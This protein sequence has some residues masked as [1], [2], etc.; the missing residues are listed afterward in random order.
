MKV[1]GAPLFP[2][3]IIPLS[4][5]SCVGHLNQMGTGGRYIPSWKRLTLK[6]SSSH[7]RFRCISSSPCISLSKSMNSTAPALYLDISRTADYMNSIL[8]TTQWTRPVQRLP[9]SGG[10]GVHAVD[11]A[12]AHSGRAHRRPST[13]SAVSGASSTSKTAAG[14]AQEAPPPPPPSRSRS[15]YSSE[16]DAGKDRS[17]GSGDKDPPVYRPRPSRTSTNGARA[18][19]SA[20]VTGSA[21]AGDREERLPSNWEKR[22]T[23]KGVP[24]ELR[25]QLQLGIVWRSNAGL[26]SVSSG[27]LITCSVRVEPGLVF[28]PMRED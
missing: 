14:P 19:D 17:I 25:R 24:C 4:C 9:S 10:P 16:K 6:R 28:D 11:A 7:I 8:K 20:N 15:S 23:S 26:C 22:F 18:R 27:R 5:C 13:V 2:E 1:P 12:Q 3:N 21:E